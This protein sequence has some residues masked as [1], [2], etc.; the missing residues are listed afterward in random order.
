MQLYYSIRYG[1]VVLGYCDK[2]EGNFIY[3]IIIYEVIVQSGF[4]VIKI[5][6]VLFKIVQNWWLFV[7]VVGL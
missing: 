2:E 4:G 1:V 7:F 5:I 3:F 6:Y